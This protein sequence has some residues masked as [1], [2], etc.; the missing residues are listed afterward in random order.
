MAARLLV[1]IGFAV[2]ALCE[3]LAIFIHPAFSSQS[4]HSRPALSASSATVSASGSCDPVDRRRRAGTH[5]GAADEHRHARSTGQAAQDRLTPF[6]PAAGLDFGPAVRRVWPPSPEGFASLK[7]MPSRAVL[8]LRPVGGALADRGW[9]GSR[10]RRR[11]AAWLAIVG[12]AVCWLPGVG[13]PRTDV[14][15]ACRRAD[16]P[17]RAAR[18]TD[19]GRPADALRP[20]AADGSASGPRR[21]RAERWPTRS[22][23][24]TRRP[25]TRRLA[26]AR[27]RSRSPRSRAPRR[28]RCRC[29]AWAP[30]RDAGRGVPGR[31]GAVQR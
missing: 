8:T 18:R 21:W 3:I 6:A 17:R 5:A 9:H 14:G 25:S 11:R 19:R 7:A 20:A 10:R 24:P 27:R 13:R 29:R 15:R 26:R 22:R 28:S 23:R 1:L 30:A 12:V 16:I 2:A 4:Y 31:R